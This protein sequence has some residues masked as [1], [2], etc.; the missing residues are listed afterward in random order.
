MVGIPATSSTC[1]VK[2]GNDATPTAIQC[3]AT[4][5]AIAFNMLQGG[6]WSG[7]QGGGGMHTGEPC[8]PARIIVTTG[9]GVNAINAWDGCHEVINCKAVAGAMT[10]VEVDGDDDVHGKCTSVI[11][12]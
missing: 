2:Q 8:S 10:G 6:T 4:A 7:Y 11:K 12:H 1:T 5:G 3:P 9:A